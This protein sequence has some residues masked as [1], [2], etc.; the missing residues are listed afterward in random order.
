MKVYKSLKTLLLFFMIITITAS[1]KHQKDEKQNT[2][3]PSPNPDT[4]KFRVTFS[5]G[6]GGRI[7]A[8]IEGKNK[9]D[10]NSQV[11]KNKIVVFTAFPDETNG[12]SVSSWEITGGAFENNPKKEKTAR[13]KIN[14][15]INVSVIFKFS[16]V[17]QE[18]SYNSVTGICKVGGLTFAMKNIEAQSACTLGSS[19]QDDNPVHTANLSA[20]QIGETEISQ[21]LY[22]LI[23]QENPSKCKDSPFGSEIQGKR[24]VE[25]MTWFAAVA[26]CNK[27]SQRIK[28]L[29]DA[30]CV[31]YSDENLKT[32]YTISDASKGVT[33][34]ADFN[35]KGF[36]LPTEAEW[37]WAAK[38]GKN[39]KYAGTNIDSELTKYAWI[40]TNSSMKTHQVGIDKIL[41][42]NSANGY[43]LYDMT[44]NV[45]EWCH[46]W[47]EQELPTPLPKDYTGANEGTLR[48]FRGGG[49]RGLPNRFSEVSLR[50]NNK[51]SKADAQVGMRIVCRP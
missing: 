15:D 24:A 46:D 13:A 42:T 51:P 12:W 5:S 19:E 45:W 23:M 38:G 31:Y 18:D 49:Y 50:N 3:T 20:F 14:S 33:P 17:T 32:I 16:S 35:K 34:Y 48:C 36:R 26:F 7:E 40:K 21:E 30:N 43:G 44:G 4:E 1:C 28:E 11:E 41:G 25:N 27:L 47:Y 10:S 6:T 8:S 22:E 2:P 37:E 9:I 29:G 39:D